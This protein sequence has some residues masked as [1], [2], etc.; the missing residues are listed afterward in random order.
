MKTLFRLDALAPEGR[1]FGRPTPRT[2]LA[3]AILAASGLLASC[4]SSNGSTPVGVPITVSVS[5]SATNINQGGSTTITATVTGDTTNSGVTW[6][7]SG[8]SGGTLTNVT[9]TSVTYNAPASV[10]NSATASITATSKADPSVTNSVQITITG[11][12][13]S[14]TANPTTLTAGQAS[15]LTATV[16]GLSSPNVTWSVSPSNFGT[17]GSET[18]TTAVYSAPTT[19][20]G[21]TPVTITAT[22]VA[23]S[24]ISGTA[25]ITVGTTDNVATIIVDGGPVPGV[26]YA[27]GS[28]ATVTICQPGSTTNCVTVDHLL[29]DT[30][31]EGLRV[32]QSE[33][34]GLTLT[35]ITSS[36]LTLNDCA[37][38]V[39]GSFLW[40]E[41][42]SA[43]VHIAGETASNIPV[44]VVA[45]PS[46]GFSSIPTACSNGNSSEDQDNQTALGANGILGVGPEPTDCELGGVNYCDGS[47]GSVASVYFA[48]PCTSSSTAVQTP[49]ADQV[50]NPVV[51]FPTDKNGVI[52]TFPTV[53]AAATTVSGTLTFGIN[54]QSNNTVPSAVTVYE[55]DTS[56]SFKTTY[57]GMSLP[58]S[59]LDSGS[60]GYFIPDPNSL[61][62]V[63]TDFTSFFC[64]SSNLTGQ[65]ATTASNVTSASGVVTFEIDNTDTLFS[66]YPADAAFGNLGGP[67]GT[68]ACTG[69]PGNYSGSCSFDWGLPFFY[70][71]TNG[72]FTSIDGATV[73]GV[74]TPTPW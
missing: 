57:D 18:A 22:S 60:N 11:T 9:T 15:N 50:T 35:P 2:F 53:G 71:R 23:N 56:D 40:G 68:T 44:H 70:G 55:M 33:L 39:D 51:A 49:D 31:S 32:L 17:L 74:S 65:T 62:A 4:S 59:F 63:C 58:Q 25:T 29:V 42:A 1:A 43:D 19:V 7:Q 14:V 67:N 21:S 69:S 8:P 41:V 64:P 16:T 36:G 48:C 72:V 34:N 20:T 30:G 45:D 54:T 10:S 6:S 13:I 52:I 38:F 24:K 73:S 3:L 27:N 26:I 46:G 12:G 61:I 37:Q 66:T 5:A 47:S 28:F